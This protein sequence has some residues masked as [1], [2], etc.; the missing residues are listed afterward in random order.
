MLPIIFGETASR[1]NNSISS[2]VHEIARDIFESISSG[3][4]HIV[5][6]D[7]VIFLGFEDIFHCLSEIRCKDTIS[8]DILL[9]HLYKAEQ[10]CA[11]SAL[12]L[13]SLLAKK[14]ICINEISNFNINHF[15]NI[16][17]SSNLEILQE[18]IIDAIKVGGPECVMSVKE[19][20]KNSYIACSSEISFPII[21]IKEFGENIELQSCGLLIHD[22]VIESVSQIDRIAN[23]QIENCTPLAILS[24]GFSYEVISTLLHNWRTQKLKIIPV[25]TTVDWSSEFV[26]ND[27]SYCA[28]VDPK[29]IDA[30]SIAILENVKIQNSKIS[31]KD[32]KLIER[33]RKMLHSISKDQMNLAVTREIIETRMKFLSARKIDI[34]VGTEFGNSSK[35]ILDRIN[36][37]NRLILDS[38]RHSI[39]KVTIE[40]KK[41]I[42][43]INSIEIAKKSFH[44]LSSMFKTMRVIKNVD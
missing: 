12:I 10:A 7:R 24:R 26:V 20:N 17:I 9:R 25:T 41:F 13:L 11:G 23:W 32:K 6:G 39:A 5:L 15:E 43:P 8:K 36:R 29:I 35:I 34:N 33:S 38:R 18:K 28:D 42:V 40:G 16:V 3:N 19:S 31:T 21:Q 22:G 37:M 14:Q 1:Q 4:L 44:S 27:L 2:S 30:K